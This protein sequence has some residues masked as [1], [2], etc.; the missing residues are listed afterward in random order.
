MNESSQTATSNF[1]GYADVNGIRVYYE[2]S[3]AGKPLV[4]IHGGGSTIQ[5][6]FERVIPLFAQNRRVIAMDLQ[7]HGRTSDRNADETF[8]QDADD[9]AML[10]CRLDIGKADF[11]GFSNGATTTIQIALRHP[12]L[13]NKMV[14][15]SPLTKRSGVPDQFWGFMEQA[16]LASMPQQLQD[17]YLAVSPNPDSLRVMHDKDAR[18]MVNFTDIPDEQIA[19]LPF[20]ALIINGDKDVITPEHVIELHRLLKNSELLI[21]PGAHGEYIGEITTVTPD[22]KESELVVPLIEKFLN[23]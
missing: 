22:S 16:S 2:I 23:K 13:V 11:F 20:P 15:G 10:L 8:E 21:V 3:G 7:A 5:T 6:T 19:A 17:A 4:L 1:S 18:R 12:E 9:V 14:L